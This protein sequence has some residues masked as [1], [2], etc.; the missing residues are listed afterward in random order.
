MFVMDPHFA[1]LL[2]KLASSRRAAGLSREDV[3]KKLVLGPGWVDRFETGDR[4]PSLATLIAL[5]NLYELK[6]S[7][8]FES[9]ELTDDIFIAD[10][11]LTAKPSG[12]NLILIFQLGKYRANVELEDSS[13]DEFNAILLTLRDELATASASEAIVFSFLKAVELWPHLNPSDLWYFFISRAYQDDFNHPASSA[14][15]DWSQSWKR[16]GGWS[17]EAIFL[18]HYNPFLKQHGIELQMPDPALKREYL[19]QMDIL[20]HAGV[21][22]ADVIVVGETDTGEK[23]AYGVVHVKASFAERRTDDV[24][25]SR[26]LIQGNYASPLVTMDCKATPAARPFNK[27]ELGETQDS[28][29]KVSSKRLDIERERAFD[30]VF[31]YNTN[32]RPTP[33]GA[34]VSARIYVCG[35]QDPDDPFSRYLIR[36]WRDR[37]GA[38]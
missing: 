37:Q 16:A 17:L 15:K 28:G 27:G 29:K 26:E 34:N 6:I 19:D 18:E 1:S 3:E 35:F 32:T 20:G 38:Y 2:E 22:K 23:V 7:D 31:S 8:F 10:R 13:I 25:L 5:L 24:P 36:K 30:A 12:N 33:R 4:L 21:E 9:V 14:G 11:Y